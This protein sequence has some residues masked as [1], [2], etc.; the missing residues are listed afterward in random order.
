MAYNGRLRAKS[1]KQLCTSGEVV[2]DI[3]SKTRSTLE[4]TAMVGYALHILKLRQAYC[5]A[6]PATSSM[7]IA[8]RAAGITAV[9]L[10]IEA[11]RRYLYALQLVCNL[12]LSSIFQD[13]YNAG[14][15]REVVQAADFL[16]KR[17]SCS[18]MVVICRLSLIKRG[19]FL[20]TKERAG[21]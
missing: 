21:R 12:L 15:R 3:I 6:E 5:P 9:K 4:L 11:L 14:R 2:N 10:T 19:L 18:R 20:S 17:N 8:L 1:T 13:F 7:D 16:I